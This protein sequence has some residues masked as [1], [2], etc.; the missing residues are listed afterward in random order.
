MMLKLIH[1]WLELVNLQ[2]N[3]KGCF[4]LIEVMQLPFIIITSI[5]L[6]ARVT[7]LLT[8]YFILLQTHRGPC[9]CLRYVTRLTTTTHITHIKEEEVTII[10][11]SLQQSLS[12]LDYCCI[13][14]SIVFLH[15]YSLKPRPSSSL[16]DVVL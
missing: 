6:P 11:L 12:V 5:H 14:R 10:T 1:Q 9:Y 16:N 2:M 13:L 8:N 15:Y 7:F 4:G 3:M